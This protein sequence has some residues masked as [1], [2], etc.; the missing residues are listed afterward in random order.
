M[1]MGV[2]RITRIC[3]ACMVMAACTVAH[4]DR[5]VLIDGRVIDGQ[6]IS[7]NDSAVTIRIEAI[8]SK[9]T[10]RVDRSMIK[11]ITRTADERPAYIAVP[12]IGHIGTDVTAEALR[13][14]L[15]L[16]RASNPRCMVLAIDSPGGSII[17][18]ISIMHAVAETS[19]QVPVIAFVKQAHGGA[20]LVALSCPQVFMTPAATIGAGLP[21]PMR[22]V[23]LLTA[24]E[25]AERGLAQS[26]FSLADLGNHV[27]PTQRWDEGSRRAWTHVET[28]AAESRYRREQQ[29]AER[30]RHRENLL[31]MAKVRA[32]CNAIEKR[33]IRML[34]RADT[35][36]S[37]I[38]SLQ[39]SHEA[40]MKQIEADHHK[41]L[42]RASLQIDSIEA[43]AYALEVAD[44]RK[45]AAKAFLEA[46]I[47]QLEAER[48][49]ARAEADRLLA[50]R[51]QLMSSTAAQ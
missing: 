34:V 17:E 2:G 6:I 3:C 14:G 11:S 42:E 30:Q 23:L 1:D 36:Q 43:A 15:Q 27:S 5:V 45:A 22:Q 21:G 20:A 38:K 35:A 13:E 16:A 4:G 28:H 18:T 12:L 24:E 33:R 40:H 25:A 46:Q 8:G 44:T 29:A 31:A 7:Q 51:Q 37:K 47:S 26:A 19:R 10:R 39:A 50:R 9:L 48:A 32:E 41:A 49:S